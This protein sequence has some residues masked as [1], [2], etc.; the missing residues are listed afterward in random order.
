MCYYIH[1]IYLNSF[2]MSLSNISGSYYTHNKT[3]QN[4][5]SRRCSFYYARPH[6]QILIITLLLFKLANCC[7][8]CEYIH[9]PIPRW[10]YKMCALYMC[11]CACEFNSIANSKTETPSFK[12]LHLN[13]REI[14]KI[15]NFHLAVLNKV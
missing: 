9:L 3:I 10:S 6:A 2:L 8:D 5:R 15:T 4:F 13:L 11:V 12:W 14:K 7:G 1:C